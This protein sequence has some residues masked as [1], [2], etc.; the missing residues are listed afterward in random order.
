MSPARRF[1]SCRTS[2]ATGGRPITCLLA[3]SI[4]KPIRSSRSA[5]YQPI[6]SRLLGHRGTTPGVNCRCVQLN[7]INQRL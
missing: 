3:R 7:Q 2:T 5:Q 1:R 4:S 6:R